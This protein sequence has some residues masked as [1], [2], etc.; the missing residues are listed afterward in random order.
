[1]KTE[2]TLLVPHGKIESKKSIVP[3]TKTETCG[4]EKCLEGGHVIFCLQLVTKGHVGPLA[5]FEE[6]ENHET[7]QQKE[8]T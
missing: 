1:M 4:E 5:K 2:D 7:S 8:T 6:S 3:T